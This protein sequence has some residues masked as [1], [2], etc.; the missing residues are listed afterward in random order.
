M[1]LLAQNPVVAVGATILGMVV[2]AFLLYANSYYRKRAHKKMGRL[3]I[4]EWRK[5]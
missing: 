3:V 2:V 4:R 5:K 1:K